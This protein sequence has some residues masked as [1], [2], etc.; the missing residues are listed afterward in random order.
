M[1]TDYFFIQ[2]I[3]NSGILKENNFSDELRKMNKSLDCYIEKRQKV[4]I[5]LLNILARQQE[6]S[7]VAFLNVLQAYANMGKDA[8]VGLLNILN[9][10]IV[11]LT[12]VFIK[13]ATCVDNFGIDCDFDEDI[14]YEVI[15]IREKTLVVIN[16]FGD[17]VEVYKHK[18]DEIMEVEV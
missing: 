4:Q 17:Q 3:L 7:S 5:G 18:F 2:K 12:P 13:I 16:M 15:A 9:A 8:Q 6:K 11:Q 1:N 14:E 10:R